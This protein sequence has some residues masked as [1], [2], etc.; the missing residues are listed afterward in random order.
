MSVRTSIVA[1]LVVVAFGASPAFAQLGGERI[2]IDDVK[3]G[4][5]PGRNVGERD[6]GRASPIVKR[7]VWAPIYLELEV[8]KEIQGGIKLRVDATDADNL[9]TV[10][11]YP[12][13]KNLS[14]QLPGA[15][16]KASEFAYIP[17]V[18]SG[19]N[20]GEIKLTIVSDDGE[21][22]SLSEPKIINNT[23]FRG[24]FTYVVVSIGSRL[25]GFELPDEKNPNNTNR[26]GL[27]NGRVETSA[28]TNVREM[29]DQWFGYQ[30]ADLVVLTTGSATGD[31][32]DDLFD[33]EKSRDFKPRL[34]AL[35][36]WVRRGGRLV[37][38]VGSNSSKLVQSEL[39]RD[40]LPATMSANEPSRSV[41]EVD[42]N[43][44]SKTFGDS[45]ILQPR[46]GKFPV[47][48]LL[49]NP[50]RPAR[51]LL[52]DAKL[53]PD[54]SEFPL[55]IQAPLGIGRVTVVAFD[56][57]QSPFL[58]LNKKAEFWDWLIRTAGSERAA[59]P[60][61]GQ[62][63]NQ[64]NYSGY[65]SDV[66]DELTTG[67]RSHVE[68]FDGVPVISFGWVALFIVLYTLLI[69]PVEYLFLKKVLGRL[70]LTWITFPVIV[71]S[72]SA[73]AYF[74]AYAIKGKDLKI[75][76]IDVVDV[77]L[78]GGRVYGNTY[79]TIFSP[80]IDSYTIGVEPRSE[81][82]ITLPNEPT[83]PVLVD[84]M[85]GGKGG[86][87]GG[88]LS[89]GYSYSSDQKDGGFKT[90]EGL[91]RVPIQVWS[92][93]AFTASWSGYTDRSNPL[94]VANEPEIS[95]FHPPGDP[96]ALAGSFK[97]NLPVSSLKDAVLFYAGTAYDLRTITR[98]QTVDVVTAKGGDRAGSLKP[99]DD[100]F[101]RNSSVVAPTQN[102]NN[103]GRGSRYNESTGPTNLS[104]WGALFHEKA[105]SS[106]RLQNATLRHLDQSWR[107]NERN[108]DE[109]I[110]VAR[111]DAPSGSPTEA[112]MNDP[113][114]AS[115]TKLWLKGLPGNPAGRLEVPGTI[116]QETYIR[117]Y[118]PVRPATKK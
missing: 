9:K 68:H 48:R 81:W 76:K 16:L 29:P 7:N 95:L 20:E 64:P 112:T 42:L 84:W 78:A 60:P 58:E 10:C 100:W 71:L 63:A 101:T 99:I 83:P 75:N 66:E 88:I 41:D 5:L 52:S 111:V 118:I 55:V 109:A 40:I 38:T 3:I 62:N 77:D 54:G 51:T 50:A 19:D 80:R 73:A 90:G 32:L 26:G 2:K 59:L 44:R 30:G 53:T 46:A 22:K 67:L 47:A 14:D 79:F 11:Y 45:A 89:R 1:G 24:S 70:E 92:T 103:F 104:L 87:S 107:L 85:A 94:V 27:R 74:T 116:R 115:V 39:F 37:I 61:P 15:R 35:L 65:Q 96:E 106:G 69:G 93:K 34:S 21:Q 49:P 17:Y 72:V 102:Y 97:N 6:A 57:D 25:P 56:L 105:V 4:L 28:I 110:L 12:L 33:K 98:G 23:L 36:E 117:V 91:V 13:L 8:K 113:A 108:R 86:G 18:R 114:G 43:W 31:F 82:A